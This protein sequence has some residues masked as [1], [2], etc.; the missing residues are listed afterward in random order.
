M[1]G[2][3]V[4]GVSMTACIKTARSKVRNYTIGDFGKKIYMTVEEWDRSVLE[5]ADKLFNSSKEKQISPAFDSPRFCRDWIEVGVKTKQIS[6]HKIMCKGPKT[7]DK[8]APVI[9]KGKPVIAWVSFSES[10]PA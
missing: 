10:R 4:Y 8:G 5:K 7:D 6:R 3:C 1:S 9:R 2:F